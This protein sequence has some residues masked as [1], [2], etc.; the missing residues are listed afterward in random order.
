MICQRRSHHCRSISSRTYPGSLHLFRKLIPTLPGSLV[1][2]DPIN[3]LSRKVFVAKTRK[4]QHAYPIAAENTP[5]ETT[6]EGR[7]TRASTGASRNG[8]N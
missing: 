3:L 4:N 2:K 7:I 6:R 8:V 5:L 1:A